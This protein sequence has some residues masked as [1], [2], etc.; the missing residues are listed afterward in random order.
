MGPT[1]S[2]GAP[3]VCLSWRTWSFRFSFSPFHQDMS[4]VTRYGA[5]K[6]RS[7]RVQIPNHCNFHKFVAN[8]VLVWKLLIH[9]SKDGGYYPVGGPQQISRGLIKTIEKAGGRVLVNA[10]VDKVVLQL[11]WFVVCEMKFCYP[12]DC[13]CRICFGSWNVQEVHHVGFNR[14]CMRYQFLRSLH[15]GF[16]SPQNT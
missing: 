12:F 2:Y 9:K 14:S 6:I 16:A 8:A 10:P 4:G 13:Y 11:L 15:A 1:R 7:D 5:W 3:C